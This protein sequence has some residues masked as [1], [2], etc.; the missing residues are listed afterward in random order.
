MA[1]YSVEERIARGFL[2]LAQLWAPR[3]QDN[4]FLEGA[5][6]P[7]SVESTV[8]DLNVTGEIP[9]EL[10][11]IFA[12]IAPNPFEVPNPAI[13]HWF[14]GDGMVHGLRLAEGRALWYRNRWVGTDDANTLLGKLQAPGPRRGV[15]RVVNTNVIGHDGRLWALVEAGALP[16]EMTTELETV[17]HGLFDSD[18]SVSYTAH[19][20]LDPA[21]GELH[22]ICY[23]ALKRGRIQYLVIDSH[24]RLVR[25]VDIPVRHGPMI[26]D[27]AITASKTIIL[28]LPVTFSFMSILR[29]TTFP[30]HWNRRH[31]ARVGLLPRNGGAAD[32]RWFELDPC[33]VFHSC[34]AFDRE[35]GSVVLD[36]VVHERM[37]DRSR[38]G[39]EAHN[40][41]L[42]RWVMDPQRSDVQRQVLSD[43]S[44]EFPR[45]DERLV[46]QEYRFAYTV[47]VDNE[48]PNSPQPLYRH[49][50]LTGQVRQHSFGSHHVS[51]EAVFVPGAGEDEED[52][53]V[54]SWVY[55]LEKDSTSVVI[56]NA[57]DIEGNPQ[58]I[59]ELPVRA[60]LGFHGN[61]ISMI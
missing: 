41:T 16:V 33:Y 15:N 17:K 36:V 44:Q 61:W 8:T 32:I 47:G 46:T 56:L 18:E 34:N 50:L 43:Y 58:A 13:H 28:D 22:A 57:G 59:I 52:G 24:C 2:R 10:N 49:D 48:N 19:P 45:F 1:Q 54:M 53:W 38:Q 42:E 31:R 3:S 23:D 21:T 5:Y 25:Q 30:Y 11:G 55:D 35:D 20:H 4:I 14:V 7:V 37:F 29:G 51:S 40:I 27:C 39:P 12:R 6:A 26:H 9:E 60:P